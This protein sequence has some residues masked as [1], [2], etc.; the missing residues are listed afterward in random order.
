MIGRAPIERKMRENKLTWFGHVHCKST[1]IVLRRSDM[2]TV[3]GK[4]EG[5]AD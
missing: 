2:V 4:T 3:D 1:H 5:R